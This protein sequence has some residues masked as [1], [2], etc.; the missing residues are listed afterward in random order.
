VI[1]SQLTNE[2]LAWR[3][4]HENKESG[5]RPSHI[6]GPISSKELARRETPEDSL[7]C[8]VSE[9]TGRFILQLALS[10]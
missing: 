5:S 2:I 3:S 8:T 7:H 9:S 10:L 4:F 1:W 6:P